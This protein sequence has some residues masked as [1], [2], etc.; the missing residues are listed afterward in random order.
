MITDKISKILDDTARAYSFNEAVRKEDKNSLEVLLETA[1]DKAKKLNLLHVN[2]ANVTVESG[3]NQ[4]KYIVKMDF[5]LVTG[6]TSPSV[7]QLKQ[8][9]RNIK[10]SSEGSVAILE[11]AKFCEKENIFT[12]QFE[13]PSAF[14]V[15]QNARLAEVLKK[16]TNRS[17]TPTISKVCAP[18]YATRRQQ[19]K[20]TEST[21]KKRIRNDDDDNDSIDE[22]QQLIEVADVA[23]TNGADSESNCDETVLEPKKSLVAVEKK[24]KKSSWWWPFGTSDASGVSIDQTETVKALEYDA[25]LFVKKN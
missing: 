8:E 21:Q 14:S 19:T 6:T 18:T 25:S 17:P 13:F 2:H 22:N 15:V 5:A 9:M 1:V 23:T 7:S 4:H 12:C 11:N 24:T 3:R 16:K 20:H 10:I